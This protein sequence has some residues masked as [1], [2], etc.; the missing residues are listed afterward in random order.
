MTIA[1]WSLAFV[2]LLQ[3]IGFSFWLGKL[4]QQV[5][6]LGKHLSAVE[7]KTSSDKRDI[8]DQTASDMRNV[9]DQTTANLTQVLSE[10]HK[11]LPECQSSFIT[12]ASGISELKG[13]IDMLILL[14]NNNSK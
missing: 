12:L 14:M 8:R 2:I 3:I 4:S 9:R 11:V 5:A 13:K 1:F 10:A 6:D 7:V